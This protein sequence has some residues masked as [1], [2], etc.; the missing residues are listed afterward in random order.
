MVNVTKPLHPV[1]MVATRSSFEQA[2]QSETYVTPGSVQTLR[3]VF[4]LLSEDPEL[5]SQMTVGD[6]AARLQRVCAGLCSMHGLRWRFRGSIPLG[7]AILVA[8]HQ[9]YIDPVVLCAAFRC[10][11]IA[12]QEVASWPVVGK[13]VRALGVQFMK[14]GSAKSGAQVLRDVRIALDSGCRVLN[15][16]EGTTT[17]GEL[18]PFHS[19]VF[20]VA[21]RA[22]VPVV[23]IAVQLADLSQAWVGDDALVPHYLRLL[24]KRGCD[25]TLSAG[26]SLWARDFANAKAYAAA[27][28]QWIGTQLDRT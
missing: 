4:G 21:A 26:P 3:Q 15:F 8:N 7:P 16:P 14:R 24:W 28:H 18:R 10:I 9:S 1:R 25:L 19:G 27:A 23:P 13:A 11:P 2:M 22:G 5:S 17:R 6:K 12:K 20:G